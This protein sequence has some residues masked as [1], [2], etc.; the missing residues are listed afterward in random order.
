MILE[1]I[2]ASLPIVCFDTCGF[3]PIVDDS[4][5]RKIR[6]TNPEQSV[7]DFAKVIRNLYHHRELLPQMSDNCTAKQKMHSWNHNAVFVVEQ[8]ERLLTTN[9]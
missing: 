6:I 9:I 8:Y 3:G 4:I 1:A 7:K 5:G 2:G